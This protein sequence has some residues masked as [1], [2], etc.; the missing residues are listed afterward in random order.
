MARAQYHADFQTSGFLGSDVSEN[1]KL[2]RLTLNAN[3]FANIALGSH[4]CENKDEVV[5]TR[6]NAGLSDSCFHHSRSEPCC[7]MVLCQVPQ[8]EFCFL[9]RPTGHEGPP[10]MLGPHPALCSPL[11]P[12]NRSWKLSDLEAMLIIRHPQVLYRLPKRENPLLREFSSIAL[13]ENITL[14]SI[15]YDVRALS[16]RSD[17]SNDEI[18]NVLVNTTYQGTAGAVESG[19]SW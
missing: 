14:T 1:E 3:G 13:N 4:N 6:G 11:A 12:I 19:A 7:R 9:P 17:R 8:R 10:A 16:Q 5:H 18:R 2:A 15:G